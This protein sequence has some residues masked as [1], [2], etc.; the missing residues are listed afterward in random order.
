MSHIDKTNRDDDDDPGYEKDTLIL[1]D[2][3]QKWTQM[4]GKEEGLFRGSSFI[5]PL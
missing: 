1:K 2:V 3:D 4:N 5:V